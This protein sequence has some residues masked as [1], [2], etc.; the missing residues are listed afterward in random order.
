MSLNELVHA[1]KL[2]HHDRNLIHGSDNKTQMVKLMEETGEL[3]RNVAKGNDVQDD[4][5][6][7]LVVLINI[8]EREGLTLQGCLLHAFN[9]ISHRTGKMQNGVFVKD[10]A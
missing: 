1:V 3:A 5:G 10:G 8:V 6:D 9:E 7:M 4:V 2:W